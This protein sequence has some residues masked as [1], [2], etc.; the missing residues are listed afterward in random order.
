MA[1]YELL[2]DG[3]PVPAAL[4]ASLVRYELGYDEP[5]KLV[6]RFDT[7]FR[8]QPYPTDAL[9]EL[10]VDGT[11]R[12]V[13]LFDPPRPYISAA[14]EM[15]VE[16][17]ARDLADWAARM[18]PFNAQEQPSFALPPGPLSAAVA[19]YLAHAQV[20]EMLE[21][22][23]IA[24]AVLYTGGAESAET[25]PVSLDGASL[26]EAMRTV[27]SKAAGIAVF[28]DCS[29]DP[30]QYRFVALLGAPGYDLV[31][32]DQR[33]AALDIQ[34]SIEGRCGAVQTLAGQTTGSA[35]IVV[36]SVEV[37]TKDWPE[38]YGDPEL[39][40]APEDFWSIADYHRAAAGEPGPLADV[41]RR[42]RFAGSVNPASPIRA[43]IRVFE[44]PE[45]P[46]NDEWREVEI[47]EINFETKR[48]VLKEPA[49]KPP[50]GKRFGRYNI[51]EPGRAKGTAVRLW[52]STQASVGGVINIPAD[53]HP[54]EGFAGR[55]YQLAPRRGATTRLIS[56]PP[57]VNR[58]T[59]A[60]QAHAALSEPL[61]TGQVPI[62]GE[63]PAEL[64]GLA[65]RLNIRSASHGA[66]GYESLGAAV[67]GVRVEFDG[68]GRALV[69]LSR[70]TSQ[71]IREGGA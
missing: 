9:V 1:V 42:F 20:T 19:A 2:V 71:L 57:G 11:R 51:F 56:V 17:T 50:P 47:A 34:Q 31:V 67:K 66:T 60:Q 68:G 41:Y 44:D 36:D 7:D 10:V 64:W 48:V 38:S 46:A 6:V 24:P 55:V 3:Q 18:I 59:Y 39:E 25:F 70:D 32:D 37:L 35:D 12:F 69:E 13:G 21:Q 30:P 45:T 65:R 49:I 40:L 61:V 16:Y 52:W 5:A 43:E 33:L 23:G 53:R 4:R 54:A 14:N 22:V 27:A 62:A 8:A 29:L 58:A 63:L 15:F 26:D 28:L